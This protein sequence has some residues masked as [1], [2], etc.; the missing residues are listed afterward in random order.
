ML[1]WNCVESYAT[2]SYSEYELAVF[3]PFLTAICE[4]QSGYTTVHD[5]I[6]R[7]ICYARVY[8]CKASFAK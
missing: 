2:V 8:Y 5:K 7:V 6:V 3:R 4:Q 1:I